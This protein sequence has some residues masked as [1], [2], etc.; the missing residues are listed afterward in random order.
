MRTQ[1]NCKTED[2]P[3]LDRS[4][5]AFTVSQFATIAKNYQT[6]PS[7]LALFNVNVSCPPMQI[8]L[9]LEQSGLLPSHDPINPDFGPTTQPKHFC[10][11]CFLIIIFSNRQI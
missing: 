9:D 8:L 10:C 11:P 4:P 2:L 6:C 3:G 7:S 1:W 5:V